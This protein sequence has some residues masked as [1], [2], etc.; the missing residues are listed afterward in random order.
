MSDERA[1]D[2]NWNELLQELRVTQTGLQ[3]LTGFL[4][5]LPFQQRFSGLDSRQVVLYLVTLG[6][7]IVATVL[8]LA[9]ASFHRLL[10]RQQEKEWLVLAGN[11]CA[12]GG[13]GLSAAAVTGVAWLLFD[14]VV[15]PLAGLVAAG[16]AAT[17]FIGVW[18]LVPV[19]ARRKS[20]LARTP[21]H[22]PRSS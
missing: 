12:R 4:V 11:S 2:R 22:S 7:A 1:V 6:V 5:T 21:E 16:V 8:V 19:V 14:V 20:A 18:W 17:L 3:I 10:F 13:L 15:S 9:P